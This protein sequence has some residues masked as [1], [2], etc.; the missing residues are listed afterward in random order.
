MPNQLSEVMVTLKIAIVRSGDTIAKSRCFSRCFVRCMTTLLLYIE[1]SHVITWA[2]LMSF[3]P[4][5]K[6]KSNISTTVFTHGRVGSSVPLFIFSQHILSPRVTHTRHTLP[7][8][9]QHSNILK[10]RGSLR[11]WRLIKRHRNYGVVKVRNKL[12]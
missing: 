6:L 7:L 9:F 10:G 3:S 11:G 5:I 8:T 12:H 2:S 4:R 1:L